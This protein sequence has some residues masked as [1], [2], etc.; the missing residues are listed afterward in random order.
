[1]K[2]FLCY[3]LLPSLVLAFVPMLF[4]ALN[5]SLSPALV[6]LSLR[7]LAP[8]GCFVVPFLGSYKGLSPYLAFLPPLVCALLPAV[9]F[10][11]SPG[12]WIP[13]ICFL[14]SVLSASIGREAYVRNT[15]E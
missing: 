4:Y 11:L 9:L 3:C 12:D 13:L 6:S 15:E 14:L 1:M 10:R 8:I 2:R 5:L 7:Y